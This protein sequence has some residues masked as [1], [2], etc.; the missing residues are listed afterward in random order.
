LKLLII[1]NYDSFTF[2]LVQLVEQCGFVDFMIVKNDELLK[3]DP[4]DFQKVL[5]SPGPGTAAE[6]GELM[7]FLLKVYKTKSI[8]GICLGFEAIGEMF[9][10]RLSKMAEPMHGIK[11]NGEVTVNDT[12]FKGLPRK[13]MIGHYHSWIIYDADMPEGLEVLLKDENDLPM[14]IR[15]KRLDIKGL[16]FHPESIMTDYGKEML[17]NWLSA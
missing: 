2:N 14:A 5:I 6:A 1:D 15:H 12:I 10:A 16:M 13:F 11:N 17:F 9:G 7:E 3:A 8:L 4:N